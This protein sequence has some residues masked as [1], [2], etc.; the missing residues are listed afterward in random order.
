L[1]RST[2]RFEAAHVTKARHRRPEIYPIVADEFHALQK[3]LAAVSQTSQKEFT[4]KLVLILLG[5]ADAHS[6]ARCLYATKVQ[7]QASVQEQRV[8]LIY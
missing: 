5:L 3:A 6:P 2:D 1:E 7:Q 8:V 4:S